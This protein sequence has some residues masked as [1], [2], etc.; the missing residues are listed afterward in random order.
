MQRRKA[1]RRQP[2]L[3]ARPPARAR[4]RLRR[5]LQSWFALRSRRLPPTARLLL[6][7]AL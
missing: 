4:A 6:F 5:V 3:A 7:A 2:H 1:L